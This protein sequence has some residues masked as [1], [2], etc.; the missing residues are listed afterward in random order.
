MLFL[1]F[2]CDRIGDVVL[3]R[4]LLL[5]DVQSNTK[6]LD[7]SLLAKAVQLKLSTADVANGISKRLSEVVAQQTRESLNATLNSSFKKAFESIIVPAFQ[8]I[9][10][11]C[12][13]VR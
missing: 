13:Y 5:C 4:H 7:S 1:V 10:Y 12:A 8:V 2:A 3:S 6:P 11:G 9:F